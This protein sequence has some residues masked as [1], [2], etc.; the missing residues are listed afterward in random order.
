MQLW[1]CLLQTLA[2]AGLKRN[3]RGIIQHD[4]RETL[5][6]HR[7]IPDPGGPQVPPKSAR[8]SNWKAAPSLA[9]ML[10]WLG[11][12]LFI[13]QYY[14]TLYHGLSSQ[15]PI[16]WTP[17]SRNMDVGRFMQVLLLS[18]VWGQRT[19]GRPCSN[20]VAS[21]LVVLVMESYSRINGDLEVL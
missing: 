14:T 11:A 12:F 2:S 18:L 19:G 6:E 7:D 5:K 15:G 9:S 1:H 16:Q 21:A 10:G 13:K 8:T 4:F 20:F 17:E 3:M